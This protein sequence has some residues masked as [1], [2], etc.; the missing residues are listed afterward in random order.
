LWRT[1]ARELSRALPALDWS[2]AKVLDAAQ[3][4]GVPAI[5]LQAA[6]RS[7]LWASPATFI[8]FLRCVWSDP[9]YLDMTVCARDWTVERP[10]FEAPAGEGGLTSYV[11][12]AE[13]VG[14]DLYR[15]IDRQTKAKSVFIKSGIPGTVG[16]GACALWKELGRCLN[17]DRTFS[18]WPF[19]GDL[20]S[21][22]AKNRV[23]LGEIYPR[24]AYATALRDDPP[25]LRPRVAVAKT[26]G[27]VRGAA[28]HALLTTDWVDAHNVVINDLDAAADNEDDFDACITAAALLRCLLEG[29]P[30][31]PV[32]MTDEVAEGGILGT[33]AVNLDLTER[34]FR[35]ELRPSDEVVRG[36]TLTPYAE[37]PPRR[38]P[39]PIPGCKHVFSG[40]RGGWDGVTGRSRA[41]EWFRPSLC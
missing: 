23:I 7:P 18:I 16:S 11:R 34:I 30:V 8:E 20:E 14:V 35:P 36:D 22:L 32:R 38:Y 1:S 5:Y 24:V 9:G 21:L 6:S 4:L 13:A 10:F 33:A 29:T 28:L 25:P 26:Q 15:A 27:A 37:R 31:A 17:R 19:D 2:L 12:A 39:C 40:S 41:A 3:P